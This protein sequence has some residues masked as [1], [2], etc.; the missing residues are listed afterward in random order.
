MS[1]YTPLNFPE[2]DNERRHERHRVNLA[3]QVR[4]LRSVGQVAKVTDVS[5]GGCRLAQTDLPADAEI[6]ISI[7]GAPATRARI[8]WTKKGQ[9]G[10]EFYKPL[11]RLDLRNVMLQRFGRAAP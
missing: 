7:A 10:C 2:A 8:V 3:A 6:W 5:V 11:S 1:F 4:E 9:A